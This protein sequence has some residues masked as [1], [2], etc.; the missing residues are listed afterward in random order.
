MRGAKLFVDYC[1][2]CHSAAYMR[3]N[4]IGDD[5]GMS[6]EDVVG[7]LVK[8]SSKVG[9]TMTVT[10]TS[11]DSKVWFG[12]SPP[13]L[14][15]IARARGADWLYT[16]LR[17]FYRDESR[18]WGVN[19]TAFKDVAMPHVLWEL[20]G[21]QE[22]IIE[23]VVTEDGKELEEITGF[24]LVEPGKLS[25]KEFDAAVHDLVSFL[26]YLSEPSKLQR[27]PLGKWVL[28]FLVV[29]FVLTY[30]LKKEYWKDIH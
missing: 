27:L 3:Y 11:Q 26:V 1:L 16:Y 17:S 25:P 23:T 29:M 4:R 8:T 22:P 15:V 30:L 24:K 14:S 7:R 21:L 13:D 9:D 10:M 18:P 20:Q 28:L 6:E 5:L 19:N 12:T 2:N